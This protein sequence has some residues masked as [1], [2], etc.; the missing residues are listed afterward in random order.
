VTGA[1]VASVHIRS[2]IRDNL[3]GF[4]WVLVWCTFTWVALTAT[5][6]FLFLVRRFAL[7]L[8]GY[9][10]V[11]DAL[12]AL[13]GFPWLMTAVLRSTGPGGAPENEDFYAAG[14]GVG[15]AIASVVALGVVWTTWVLVPPEQAART[16]SG[17][18]TN[19]VGL[20]LSVAWPIQCGIGLVVI[21]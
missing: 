19:R 12:W 1:A 17:P 11:G 7:R 8:P 10:K 20:L 4:G 15:L 3:N 14:L 9:P 5:G 16:A 13:L 18:W 6:P 2:V 21:S